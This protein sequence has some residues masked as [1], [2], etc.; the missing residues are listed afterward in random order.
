MYVRCGSASQRQRDTR[1]SHTRDDSLTLDAT[2]G[3]HRDAFH[4]L[5]GS[6]AWVSSG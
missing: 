2:G 4:V 1:M 5:P 6:D 3:R